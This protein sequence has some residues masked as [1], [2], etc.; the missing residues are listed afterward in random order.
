MPPTNRPDANQKSPHDLR[1][2]F[3]KYQ[4]IPFSTLDEDLDVIDFARSSRFTHDHS[5]RIVRTIASHIP[6]KEFTEFVGDT[7]NLPLSSSIEV[8]E[9]CDFPGGPFTIKNQKL[10]S[11]NRVGIEI[12]PNL[13][14]NEV[15]L[16]ILSR[17]LHRDLANPQHKTNIHTHYHVPYELSR[18]RA[19]KIT[20][21]GDQPSRDDASFFNCHPQCSHT[22]T[23]VSPEEHK[24]IVIAQFL[25]KKLRWITLGGQYDW[26]KKAYP[27]G[28]PP[29]FPWD[30]G[31]LVHRLF[32]DMNPEAAI[33]NLYSPGDTLSLHRDVSEDSDCGLV[34]LS[35]GCDGLFVVGMHNETDARTGYMVL[36]LRSGDAVYM[37]GPNRYAWHG[38]PQI[39][40]ETCPKWLQSWP[41]SM[42]EP[43]EAGAI[44]RAANDREAWRGWMANKR[45]NL[46]VRQMKR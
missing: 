29:Q 33:V 26:T 16:N 39:L 11:H 25:H 14:P 34:S 12:I 31:N 45:I 9:H 22:F 15:Q 41:A 2:V 28:M 24:P 40:P 38:V 30:I 37:S 42:G 8:F 21:T 4:K 46:N 19:E 18:S 17:L 35:L 7:A 23:P 20:P 36:R 32:P 13:L 10:F 27:Q 1:A 44:E 3:K 43:K 5:I 6:R